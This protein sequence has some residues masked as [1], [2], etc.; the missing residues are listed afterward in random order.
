MGL[1]TV[2][3]SMWMKKKK[4]KKRESDL[5]LMPQNSNQIFGI[6]CH[7]TPRGKKLST[8]HVC[9]ITSDMTA[10]HDCHFRQ[11]N[12]ADFINSNKLTAP[13]AKN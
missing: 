12:Y 4:K 8:R 5:D 9:S 11:A 3:L 7:T 13:S 1:R 10:I 6:L 2:L